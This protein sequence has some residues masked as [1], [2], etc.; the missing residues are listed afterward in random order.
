M[1][2]ATKVLHLCYK[3]VGFADIMVNESAYNSV[4][5]GD[6][7][8]DSQFLLRNRKSR[9]LLRHPRKKFHY[10]VIELL[11]YTKSTNKMSAL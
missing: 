9:F 5:R 7:S 10:Q 2:H 3:M 4:E 11:Q 8:I 1:R 6:W